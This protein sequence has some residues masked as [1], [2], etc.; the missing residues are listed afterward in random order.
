M[1]PTLS[2][3][4]PRSFARTVYSACTALALGTLLSLTAPSARAQTAP[5]NATIGNQASATYSDGSGVTRTTT[6]NTV[7]TT[8]QQV[9]ALTLTADNTKVA[10]PGSPIYYPHTVTNTGNG[11]DVINLTAVNAAGDNFDLTNLAVFADSDGNGVP[12]NNTPITV[13]PTLAPGESFRFVVSGVVPATATSTQFSLVT[14]TATSA[15]SGTVTQSNTDRVTVTN[16]AAI[17]V[18][19]S[20]S[21]NSGPAGTNGVTYTLTYRNTGNTAATAVALTDQIPANLTYVLGSG[22]WSKTGATALTD[23]AAGDPVAADATTINYTG[24]NVGGTN[25]RGTVTATISSVA[26]QSSGTVSFQVNVNGGIAP[27]IINNQ[28]TFTYNDGVANQTGNSNTVPFTVTT[29]ASLTFT[30]ATVPT[31]NEGSAVRFNNVLTN[32]GKT[33]PHRPA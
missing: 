12:D 7:V 31:A 14:V 16:Q 25:G 22:R 6:S 3:R 18:T 29:T 24:T 27:Q 4:T 21:T 9:P 26:A 5:A 2:R 32:T 15:S 23:A 1:K 10:N 33:P 19:K 28:A 20:I 30:G 11:N 8:V 13:T 17:E